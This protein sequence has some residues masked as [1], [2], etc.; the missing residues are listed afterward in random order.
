M[1]DLIS[2]GLLLYSLIAAGGYLLVISSILFFIE[3]KLNLA[4]EIPSQLLEKFNVGWFLINFVMEFLFFA[5]IPTL[6]FG[7]FYIILPLTGMRA[8]MAVALV[9]FTLGAVPMVMG[10]SMRIK[11]PMQFM[12]YTLLSYLLKIGGCMA[13]IGYLYSI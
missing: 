9:A 5:V 12:L 2:N 10:Y 6:A 8:G 7:F 13:I 11:F 3:K 4:K 1:V